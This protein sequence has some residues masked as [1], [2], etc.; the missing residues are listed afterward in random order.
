ML[1]IADPQKTS[2]ESEFFKWLSERVTCSQLSDYYMLFHDISMFC[3]SK[4]IINTELFFIDDIS[5]IKRVLATIEESG[6]FKFSHIREH[7]KMLACIRLYL[8]F[9][10]KLK[11]VTA[12]T[13]R[14]ENKLIDKTTFNLKKNNSSSH[15]RVVESINHENSF[16]KWM[17]KEGMAYSSICCYVSAI[18]TCGKY[19]N[20]HELLD[21][22]IFSLITIQD[23]QVLR[24][25]LL[26]DSNF[27][28]FNIMKHYRY[29]VALAKYEQFFFF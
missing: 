27:A 5:L 13:I 1:K 14:K 16:L 26:E 6:F 19:A 22:N 24:D 20:D 28:T 8:D 18:K 17:S 29:S 4:K 9:C 11:T 7:K 25:K 21:R 10:E 2:H 3:V 23:V 12:E 15:Y